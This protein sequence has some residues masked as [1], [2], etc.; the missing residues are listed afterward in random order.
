MTTIIG[1]K[2]NIEEEIV[3]L[4]TDTQ[5]NYLDDDGHPIGKKPILKIVNGDFW[6]LAQAGADTPGLRSFYR[7]RKNPDDRRYKDYSKDILEKE[8]D[9][10]IQ[11]KRY[12]DVDQLNAEYMADDGDS[13]EAHEFLMAINRPKIELYHIDGWG[14]LKD[15]GKGYHAQKV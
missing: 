9:I 15:P 5:M 2:T 7:K 12:M 8:L 10:A 3:I 4:G 1:I 11:K 14:N 6:V 13:D